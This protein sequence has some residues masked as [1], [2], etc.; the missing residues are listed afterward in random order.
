MSG[1]FRLPASRASTRS[2]IAECSPS[3]FTPHANCHGAL[4]QIRTLPGVFLPR[5]LMKRPASWPWPNRSMSSR[6]TLNS[7]WSGIGALIFPSD[8]ISA[9]NVLPLSR[10][11]NRCGAEHL[12]QARISVGP[13]STLSSSTLHGTPVTADGKC[14]AVKQCHTLQPNAS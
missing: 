12:G 9:S 14:S 13:G 1:A 6:G 8:H 11:A 4:T 7:S 3:E 2:W 10:V 5:L